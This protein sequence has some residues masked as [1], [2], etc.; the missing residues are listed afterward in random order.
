M[1]AAFDHATVHALLRDKRL[2]REVPAE[3]RKPVPDHLQAFDAVEKHSMLEKEGDTHRRL[4]GLV[5]RAFTSRR[6]A[7]LND[8]VSRFAMT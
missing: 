1:L 7:N 8:D 3:L 6:I 5:L 2:G 4:R